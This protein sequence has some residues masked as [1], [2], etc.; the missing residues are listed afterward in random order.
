MPAG[1]S[2]SSDSVFSE[3]QRRFIAAGFHDY[4]FVGP[5][6]VEAD[7]KPTARQAY[8]G[9][10]LKDILNGRT[11]ASGEFQQGFVQ[12]L[13]AFRPDV[14]LLMGGTNDIGSG[15][16]ARAKEAFTALLDQI[17]KAAP[18]AIVFVHPIPPVHSGK[19]YARFLPRIAEL[20][21]FI[22]EEVDTRRNPNIRLVADESPLWEDGDFSED[23]LHPLPSGKIKLASS[24]YGALVRSGLVVES[25]GVPK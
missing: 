11:L 15:D 24:W 5:V 21:A 4:E 2:L 6:R 8:G 18:K 3:L 23:G 20:N 22:A 19:Q 13:P 16:A 7:P 12:T 10:Q 9:A 14:I 1:D 17:E 25:S